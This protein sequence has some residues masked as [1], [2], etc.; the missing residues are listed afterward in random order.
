MLEKLQSQPADALLAL[1]KM[2]ADDEREDKIDLGV[3]VYRTGE[4]ATPVF[5]AIKGAE[6]RLLEQQDSKSYLGPRG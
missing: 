2:Y 5:S 6:T 1:I 4:G 3:G